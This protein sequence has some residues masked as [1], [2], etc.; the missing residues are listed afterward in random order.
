[1]W[2]RGMNTA[3]NLEVLSLIPESF[4][5]VLPR[6]LSLSSFHPTFL[7]SSISPL[8]FHLLFLSYTVINHYIVYI[9]GDTKTD[10]A[11][12]E[13]KGRKPKKLFTLV[14]C[15]KCSCRG[16]RR[17]TEKRETSSTWESYT[18][19]RKKVVLI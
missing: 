2:H 6:Y 14:L 4:Y 9:S 10:L 13:L 3:K 12:K 19:S 16:V 5:A 1:M 8:H 11:L 7:F 18:G 17:Y 15:N